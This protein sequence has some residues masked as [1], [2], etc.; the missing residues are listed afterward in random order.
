MRAHGPE[1]AGTGDGEPGAVMPPARHVRK[2]I[3]LLGIKLM[4]TKTKLYHL[5]L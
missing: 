5:D 1:G 3:P 4:L 2:V